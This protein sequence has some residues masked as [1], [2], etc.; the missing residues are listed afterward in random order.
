MAISSLEMGHWAAELAISSL[1]MGHW[2]AELATSSLEMGHWAAELAI[3]S[4]ERGRCAS[5]RGLSR[6]RLR[7]RAIR[8]ALPGAERRGRLQRDEALRRRNDDAEMR[9]PTALRAVA[10]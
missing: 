9:R 10:R 3:S 5:G 6:A 8:A 2:A 7:P 1:E 4:L